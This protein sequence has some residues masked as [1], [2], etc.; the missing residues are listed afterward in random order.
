MKKF[1]L[2]SL[3]IGA[4]ALLTLSACSE[5]SMFEGNGTGTIMPAVS[6]DATVVGLPGTGS[7]AEFDELTVHDL[8][9]TIAKA[10]GSMERTIAYDDFDPSEA[11]TVGKYTMTASYGN[12][13]DEG[14]SKTAV[15]G[16]TEF[17]VSEGMATKVELIAKPSKAMV[18]LEFDEALTNYL[19]NLQATVRTAYSSTQFALDETRHIYIR[20][21]HVAVDLSFTKPNGVS[22]NTEVYS[23]E[24]QERHR[25]KVTLRLAKDAG[26]I[27]GIT[28]T[29]DDGLTEENVDIDI[30]DKVLTLVAPEI[31]LEGVTAGEVLD[32]VEGSALTVKP[33][34][35][36][37]A[38][39]PIKSALLVTSGDITEKGWPRQ[40]DLAT[41]SQ[42]QL[43]A[44]ETMGLRGASTFRNGSKYG[45]L[46]FSEVVKSIDAT[47]ETA[48]PNVFA[49]TVTDNNG[50]VAETEG[51]GLKV[52]KLNL[53]LNAIDG[54]KYDYSPTVDVTMDYNGSSPLEDVVKF[55]YLANTGIFKPTTIA[56]VTA[57]RSTTTYI[58][59]V[60]I[61]EDAATPLQLKATGGSITTEE[62]TIPTIEAPVLTVNPN[63]VYATSLYASVEYVADLEGKP[64]ELQYSTDGNAF[65]GASTAKDGGDYRLSGSLR[66]ATAYKIRAKVGNIVSNVVDV[67]TEPAVQL[68]NG[69]MESW[70]TKNIDCGA[71]DMTS[72]IPA[73]PW[74]TL[75]DLT[76]SSPNSLDGRSIHVATV[77]T[78]EAHSGKAAAI[79]TVGWYASG[80]TPYNKQPEKHTAGELF[81]GSYSG[82]ANYGTAFTS[83]PSALKFW[84]KFS[85]FNAGDKALAEVE[86]LDA[87]GNVIA[88]GRGTYSNSATY[89][90]ATIALTYSRNSAKAAQLRVKFRS[91]DKA[92]VTSADVSK[93]TTG[94]F[95]DHKQHATGATFYVDD[96]TLVY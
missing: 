1:K 82:G 57:A 81:L 60:N 3:G 90:E 23:F 93:L 19:N 92:E 14:F 28:V 66:P 17:V 52:N 42:T 27:D 29:Y 59:T 39:S 30:S 10:D 13:E 86:V 79:R 89:N 26:S 36:V 63:N 71:Y 8:T 5:E 6:Y 35:K 21:G 12:P 37:V 22:G 15:F 55:R 51:F 2:L 47:A 94:I 83:R 91:S 78:N 84:Y 7:R 69:D 16:S 65:T 58:V 73:T 25:Y 33:T 24:A 80:A 75:N 70:S 40:I 41:A 74:A 96:I 88:S 43:A 31:S 20:P 61:P 68:P 18:A 32:V 56:G 62:I 64:V 4:A 77:E 48:A 85:E 9:L 95:S 38:K 76:T 50:K 72:Y 49:L 53:T 87:S 46:E 67:T 45:L 54:I 11:F 44:L 34:M